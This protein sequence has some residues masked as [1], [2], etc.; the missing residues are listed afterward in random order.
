MPGIAVELFK[1]HDF[2]HDLFEFSMTLSLAVSF[3]N[4]KNFPCFR[5]FFD[6]NSLTDIN[7]GVNQNAC[8]VYCLITPLYL[9][10]SLPCHLWL[11]TL[12]N[13]TLIFHDFQG[14]TFKFHDFPGLENEI[15]TFHD[16]SVF[17]WRVRTLCNLF[18]R[19]GTEQLGISFDSVYILFPMKV[20][21]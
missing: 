8:R 7:S 1:F 3:K 10:L 18:I 14:P 5:V 4:F 13:K 17:P 19:W 21:S 16:F 15:L 12:Q 2:F 6:L 11:L 9:A 20:T